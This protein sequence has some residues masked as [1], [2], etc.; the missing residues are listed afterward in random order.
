LSQRHP[1]SHKVTPLTV[2][3]RFM[4]RVASFARTFEETTGSD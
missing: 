4:P 3:I 1:A 2:C